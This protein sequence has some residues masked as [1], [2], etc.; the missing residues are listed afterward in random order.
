MENFDLEKDFL[1]VGSIVSIRFNTN[2]FMIMGFCT[3]D[4]NTNE[5]YDYSAV[6]YPEGLIDLD[7]VCM[8]NR[9]IVKKVFHLGFID[10]DEK[11]FKQALNEAIARQKEGKE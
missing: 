7:D 5:I 6:P 10:D 9:A 4:G 11:K 1:P 2:K 8:F 3:F